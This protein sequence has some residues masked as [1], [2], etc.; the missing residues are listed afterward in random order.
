DP[1]IGVAERRL[2]DAWQR[3]PQAQ[4]VEL[5]AIEE[6]EL[7]L[8]RLRR[9]DQVLIEEV[10]QPR[11]TIEAVQGV[12]GAFR[13][14]AVCPPAAAGV[15]DSPAG[16]LPSTVRSSRPTRKIPRLEPSID[17]LERRLQRSHLRP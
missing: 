8:N 15:L 4:A 17:D 6:R 11:I 5:D 2:V 3:T 16:E 9:N 14:I 12:V 1:P 7:R 10:F 13:R